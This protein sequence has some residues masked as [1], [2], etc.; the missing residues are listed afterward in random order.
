MGA[1]MKFL[2]SA[3]LFLGLCNFAVAGVYELTFRRT[4]PVNDR[5][6]CETFVEET[7]KTFAEQ[8]GAKVIDFGCNEDDYS[9][10]G[11]DAVITYEAPARLEITTTNK[12]SP[13]SGALYTSLPDCN[14]ALENQE[15]LFTKVT[16]LPVLASY[17]QLEVGAG[18][19]WETRVDGIGTSEM[20]PDNAAITIYGTITDFKS[21]AAA[22]YAAAPAYGITVSEVGMDGGGFGKHLVVRFYANAFYS[23]KDFS[24]MKFQ[25]MSTCEAAAATTKKFLEGTDKP[26]VSFCE[27]VSGGVTLHVTNFAD[28][29]KPVNVFKTLQLSKQYASIEACQSGLQSLPTVSDAYG[30]VCAGV[31]K[32]VRAFLFTR[33]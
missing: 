28:T 13:Y 11:L 7:A 32:N 9:V 16:H 27:K 1:S 24:D 20:K 31:A 10:R 3:V 26:V 21:I 15:V 18:R 6:L 29:L 12:V 33:P 19:R 2:S 23:L 30:V 22:Y 25:D 17:C 8:S 5:K 4:A 14:K